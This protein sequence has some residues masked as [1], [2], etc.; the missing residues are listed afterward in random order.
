MSH[1]DSSSTQQSPAPGSQAAPT[2]KFVLADEI[3]IT[4]PASD[5]EVPLTAP[6]DES[7]EV[8]GQCGCQGTYVVAA[9]VHDLDTDEVYDSDPLTLEVTDSVPWGPVTFWN[10]GNAIGHSL[11]LTAW[12]VDGCDTHHSIPIRVKAAGFSPGP[13]QTRVLMTH[14]A[15]E[16]VGHA[17]A[18]TGIEPALERA[19]TSDRARIIY[20]LGGAGNKV[21][22]TFP[23]LVEAH[24]ADVPVPEVMAA[25]F[26]RKGGSYYFL[27]YGTMRAAIGSARLFIFKGIPTGIYTIKTHMIK[28]FNRAAKDKVP[29]VVVE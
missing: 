17:P 2:K 9:Q 20:P 13:E 12:V 21:K 5:D 18:V 19:P 16:T 14:R 4:S 7:F 22:S 8:A 11:R 27:K 6:P 26:R 25:I 15:H 24:S 23:L 28:P 1:H 10:M 3:L 29:N